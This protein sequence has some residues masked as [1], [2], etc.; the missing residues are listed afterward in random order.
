MAVK[1]LSERHR[2]FRVANTLGV[3]LLEKVYENALVHK[4][5]RAGIAVPQQHAITV[6]YDGVVVG[7]YVADLLA[8]QVLVV[9]LKSV[10]ALDQSDGAQCLNYLSSAVSAANFGNSPVEIRRIALR[11]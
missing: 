4:V 1:G 6:L 8:E 7:D 3:G 2:M 10:M 5:R 9:E 11:L